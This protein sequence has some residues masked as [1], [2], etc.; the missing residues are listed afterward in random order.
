MVLRLISINKR[1]EGA[2][3]NLFCPLNRNGITFFKFD[4]RNELVFM[5]WYYEPIFMEKV[6][7]ES[8]FSIFVVLRNHAKRN[9]WNGRHFETVH[10]IFNFFP[11]MGL[12]WCTLSMA[13]VLV[14][15][16]NGKVVFR[17]VLEPPLCTNGS[18]KYLRHLSVKT[19]KSSSV[20]TL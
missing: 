11:V 12:C 9:Q 19:Y 20:N 10:P 17:G 1:N 8:G 2:I 3:Q 6:L 14:E 7:R 18:E 5:C 4:F 15:N 16:S 13:G